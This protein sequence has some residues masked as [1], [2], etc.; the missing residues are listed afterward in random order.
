MIISSERLFFSW[1]SNRTVLFVSSRKH[2]NF[3]QSDL[4]S[5]KLGYREEYLV[6]ISESIEN[7]SFDMESLIKMSYADAVKYLKPFREIGDKVANCI[8]LFGLY[9]TEAFPIDV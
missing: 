5:I 9:K 2:L 1:F 8:A 7:S 6:K 3:F 4:N